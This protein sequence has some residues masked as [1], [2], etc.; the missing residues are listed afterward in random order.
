MP[1]EFLKSTQIVSTALGLLQRD[2]V[3]PRLV[4]T[5]AAGDFAGAAGDTIS[6]RLPARTTASTRA[7]RSGGPLEIGYLNETKV[8]V[9]LDTDVYNGVEVSD[10]ELTLDITNF[11]AQVLQPQTRAVAEGVEDAV[12][13]SMT[14]AT[15][16]ADQTI[17]LDT[18]NPYHTAVDAREALNNANV[19]V[20]NRAMLVGSS[21]EAAFLK[22]DQFAMVDQSGSDSALRDAQI[23]RVAGMP[24]YTSNALPP[25]VG[26][27][28]H[29]TA[30]V[31]S[32]RA[33]KVP[34]GAAYGSSQSYQGVAMR[35]IR[36]Y[37]ALNVRD[38]SILSCYIGTN[39][40]ADGPNDSLV[41]AVKIT[42]G[43][44]E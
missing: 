4:W 3:V 7:L 16:G 29:K 32:M 14:S 25:D 27:A 24:V 18:A 8:D 43:T 35:W 1:N 39:V 41:R 2:I 26:F 9:S 31:L 17:A 19:P 10:E 6:L 33:P 36:D 44:G 37:D 21:I 23:G 28:F 11:G 34:D 38:R 42:N 15:Y 20:A 30:F 40:V 22:S 12:V 5:D 13:A